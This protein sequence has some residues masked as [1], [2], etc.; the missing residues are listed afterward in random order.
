M[1][2]FAGMGMEAWDSKALTRA[3]LSSARVTNVTCGK[4]RR[5]ARAF[6]PAFAHPGLG[7]KEAVSIVARAEETAQTTGV[8]AAD[9]GGHVVVRHLGLPQRGSSIGAK[10]VMGGMD[11]SNCR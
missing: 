4:K 5:A 3:N 8:T 10:R 9:N 2:N 1:G 7:K 11:A 6:M